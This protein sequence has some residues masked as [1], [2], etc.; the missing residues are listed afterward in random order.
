MGKSKY[1]ARDTQFILDNYTELTYSHIAKQLNIFYSFEKFTEKQV[2]SKARLMGLSKIKYK[3]NRRFFEVINSTDKGYWLGFIYADGYVIE[4]Y[5]NAEIS[6]QLSS[7]DKSHL[8][9]LNHSI[10]G[11]V[12][13]TDFIAKEVTIKKTGQVIPPRPISQIRLYSLEMANDLKKLNL[14]QNKTYKN[15]SPDLCYSKEINLAIIR[16]FFDGDGS[17]SKDGQCHFTAYSDV[18]LSKIQ[19]YLNTLGINSSMYIEKEHKYRLFIDHSYILKFLKLLY[20]D[21]SYTYLDRKYSLAT[22]IIKLKE[23]QYLNKHSL[24]TTVNSVNVV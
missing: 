17:L 21:T 8:E 13:V 4:T 1:S 10:K 11:D 6:I 19:K 2:R 5:R 18:F 7:I 16:G 15:I 24:Y 14:V 3:Y 22:K 20:E 23:K 9:K 12:P